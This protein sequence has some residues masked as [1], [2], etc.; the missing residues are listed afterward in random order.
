MSFYPHA[1]ICAIQDAVY[2]RS[3]YDIITITNH[4]VQ[5]EWRAAAE[6][7]NEEIERYDLTAI[8]NAA[9]A[10]ANA[11]RA[12]YLENE[13][14]YRARHKSRAIIVSVFSQA[15]RRIGW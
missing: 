4:R 1:F 10:Y 13:L 9:C 11:A 15:A 7:P 5:R 8:I 12:C 14:A 6:W 2:H 3:L